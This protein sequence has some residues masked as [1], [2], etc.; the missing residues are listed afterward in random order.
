MNNIRDKFEA[1]A[2]SKGYSTRKLFDGS[3]YCNDG[4]NISL[5]AWQAAT[6]QSQKEI[7]GLE[8]K[9]NELVKFQSSADRL[10][11]AQ[12]ESLNTIA[13]LKAREK[14]LVNLAKLTY[15]Y[16]W[17][18]NAGLDAPAILNVTSIT[19]EKCS[20][21]VRKLWLDVLTKEQRGEGINKAL[22]ALATVRGE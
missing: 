2:N 14:E 6:E 20:H 9:L 1:W 8:A 16:L 21:I 5:E 11:K 7:A 10:A 15:G 3:T 18:I 4:I 12:A 22:E 19:P 13:E 17:H